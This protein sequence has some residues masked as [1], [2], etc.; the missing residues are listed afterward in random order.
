MIIHS[1]MLQSLVGKIIKDIGYNINIIDEEGIIVASGSLERIG[2]FH[3]IGKEA[4]MLEKRI[5]INHENTHLYDGVKEGINQPFYYNNKIAGVIG[6]TGKPER[7]EEFVN[8]VKSMIELMI[9]QEVLKSKM[10]HRQSNKV[11]FLNLLMNLKT[12]EDYISVVNWANQSKYDLNKP[13]VAVLFSV[14]EIL[15]NQKTYHVGEDKE[16]VKVKILGLLKNTKDHN[17]EDISSYITPDRIVVLKVVASNSIKDRN[18]E[19]ERY[20]YEIN[21]E[22]KKWFEGELT[23]GIGSVYEEVQLFKESYSEAEYTLQKT[24]AY[25]RKERAS[26]IKNDLLSYFCSK[27]PE[28]MKHHFFNEYYQLISDKQ[29]LM[30]TVITLAKCNMN[31]LSASQQLYVH[32]NTVIVR[33]N[34]LKELFDLDPFK[35][36]EDKSMWDM[37]AIYLQEKNTKND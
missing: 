19:I 28:E 30:D 4:A 21:E 13:R 14:K 26:H 3:K 33:L 34:R 16:A 35:N 23:V 5:D 12:E 24:I 25:K 7:I 20:V 8:V 11:F 32:R 10:Y 15:E 18:E 31:I 29:E 2:T 1:E 37:L 9:E 6:I 17:R 27:L 36:H 22:L